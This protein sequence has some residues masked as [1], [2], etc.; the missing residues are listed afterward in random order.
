MTKKQAETV[1]YNH[2]W[3]SKGFCKLENTR[4]ALMIYDW[5]ITSGLAVKQIRKLLNREYDSKLNISNRMDDDM[6]HCVNNVD[7]QEKLLGRIA[8][9]RKDYYRS[10]TL[11]DGKPNAQVKFLTGWINRVDDCLTVVV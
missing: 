7:N 10:L 2:Y 1:Y 3:K 8:D 6:I 11:T 5:T 9:V 4:I